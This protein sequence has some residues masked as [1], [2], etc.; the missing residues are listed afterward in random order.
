[1]PSNSSVHWPYPR[2][3][4]HRGG[5]RIAPENTLAG[6]RCGYDHGFDMS[7]FDVKLSQD[8]VLIILHD[9]KVDRTSNG[10]GAAA[11]M[12]FAELSQLDMGSWHSA[13]YAGEPLPAFSQF[14]R[15]ILENR[16]LCNIEIKPCPGREQE[17]G[18]AV[19]EAVNT[20]W[21]DDATA[22]LVSSFSR[23]SLAAFAQHAPGVPRAFLID[24]LPEDFDAI[25]Q[26][27][28]CQS[29]NLNQK[30]LDEASISRIHAAG[31]KVCAYTVNDYQ[32]AKQLL[33]WGCDAIFT[34][35]LI[36]IPADLGAY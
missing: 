17:T 33:G 3:I 9:D 27:L 12:P 16:L 24:E 13:W 31:Y 35:E 23:E 7:E 30:N 11:A 2:V 20:W 1:M 25:L 8:N 15:F 28:G 6:L 18:I 36:R 4:A 5:G 10:T 21:R 34:D 26:T 32:R 29:I 14:V 19:A 22:P